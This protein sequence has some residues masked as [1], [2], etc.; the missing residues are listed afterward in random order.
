MEKNLNKKFTDELFQELLTLLGKK[1][2][3]GLGEW[4]IHKEKR[5]GKDPE[6]QGYSLFLRENR[7]GGWVHYPFTNRVRST[8]QFKYALEMAVMAIK[9]Y[10]HME[11]QKRYE[12]K[13]R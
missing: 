3:E 2:G 9:E 5:A 10:K 6:R 4:H 1:E 11:E 7:A 12:A 13:R 8:G